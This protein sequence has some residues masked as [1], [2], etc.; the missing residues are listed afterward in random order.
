MK[1]L[2]P[3]IILSLLFSSCAHVYFT[4]P[5]PDGGA[6]I[7]EIPEELFGEWMD[8]NGGLEIDVTGIMDISLNRNTDGNIID[9]SYRK[10]EL[11]DTMRLYKTKNL[12]VFNYR[13]GSDYWELVVIQKMKNGDIKFYQTANPEI[14]VKDKR[15]RL[16]EAKYIIDGEEQVV[17]DLKS[18]NTDESGFKFAVFSGQMKVKTLRK[19]LKEEYLMVALLNDGTIYIPQESND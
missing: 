19:I 4:E 12:Y 18:D 15:L 9:T 17:N 3:L 14:F 13:D 2:F 8:D 6:R 1:Y 7:Y 16:E 5:Q 11:S 10:T